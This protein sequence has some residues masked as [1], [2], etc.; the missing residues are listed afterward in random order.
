M[1]GSISVKE[2]RN[3]HYYLCRQLKSDGMEILM[4]VLSARA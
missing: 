2:S 1:V 3:F 4:L